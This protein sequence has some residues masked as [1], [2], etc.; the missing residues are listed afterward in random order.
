AE[1]PK[2]STITAILRRHGLTRHRARHRSI[3]PRTQP[4]EACNEP[5]DTW[6]V[7]FKGHFRTGDGTRVY[8]LTIMDACSRFLIRCQI[9]LEPDAR[10]VI[11][12]FHSAFEEFG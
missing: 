7:D 4:F 8:P 5:N 1:M 6:C 3:T 9:V 10:S 11:P 2:E 12:I